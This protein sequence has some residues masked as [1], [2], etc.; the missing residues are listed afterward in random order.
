MILLLYMKSCN[1]LVIILSGCSLLLPFRGGGSKS[2]PVHSYTR[3]SWSW[4]S[5]GCTVSVKPENMGKAFLIF[6]YNFF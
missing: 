1:V 4:T 2:L 6:F 5:S 3:C